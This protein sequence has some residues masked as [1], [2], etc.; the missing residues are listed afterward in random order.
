MK[1]GTFQLRDLDFMRMGVIKERVRWY[2]DEDHSR[3]VLRT[4]RSGSLGCAGRLYV[5]VWN[6]TYVCRDNVKRGVEA[7][8]Y[9]EMTVPAL[10]GLLSENGICRGY[11]MRACKPNR[12]LDTAFYELV[13]LRTIETGLFHVQFSRYHM[14]K[15]G[16]G[17]SL[18]DLEG[19]FPVSALGDI[20]LSQCRFDS[21]DYAEFVARLYARWMGGGEPTLKKLEDERS[22]KGRR[23]PTT[24]A[25]HLPLSAASKLLALFQIAGR[26]I[27]TEWRART[28]RS[29]LLRIERS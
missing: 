28:C 26:A 2:G 5:K 29:H 8:F 19:L 17:F 4:P 3:W 21:D 10:V 15:F 18:I 6:P 25:S 11:V 24:A 23:A 27:A 16:S 20:R 12:T 9:D 22:A 1:V 14:M 7:G 13:K